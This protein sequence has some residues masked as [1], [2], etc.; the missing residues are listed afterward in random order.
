MA[1]KPSIPKGTRDFLPKQSLKRQFIFD[2][3]KSVFQL[4]GYQPIETPAMENLDTLTGKYG[5]E[6]DKLIYK[7]LNNGDFLSKANEGDL[8]AKNSIKVATQ[9][10]DRALRYDLTVPFARFVVMCLINWA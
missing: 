7:I 9:I 4:Y 1:N 6:G 5:E 2:T 3:A 10:S 8:G